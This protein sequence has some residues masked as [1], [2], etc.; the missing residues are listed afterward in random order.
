MATETEK[1]IEHFA[2]VYFSAIVG[3]E[4]NDACDYAEF[5]ADKFKRD[6][7]EFSRRADRIVA[8]KIYGESYQYGNM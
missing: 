1:A 6:F 5:V 8:N 4:W 2:N 7:P 3:I